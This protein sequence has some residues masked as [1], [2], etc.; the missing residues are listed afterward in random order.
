MLLGVWSLQG[1]LRKASLYVDHTGLF[2][3]RMLLLAAQQVDHTNGGTIGHRVKK[4]T[5]W[6]DPRYPNVKDAGWRPF[7]NRKHKALN[8]QIIMNQNPYSAANAKIILMWVQATIIAWE[9]FT[10]KKHQTSVEKRPRTPNPS[11]GEPSLK[12]LWN[13]FV[14]WDKA[15]PGVWSKFQS[16]QVARTA[17][18]AAHIRGAT[19][20]PTLKSP[21]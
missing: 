2:R 13:L 18:K 21:L 7:P 16:C 12:S 10:Y 1:W 8:T 15:E 17:N 3:N 5:N 6:S 20:R 14:V 4:R 11:C 9:A 19:W